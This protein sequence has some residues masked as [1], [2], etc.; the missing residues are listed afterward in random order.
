MLDL[1]L[2]KPEVAAW[3]AR[4]GATDE[5]IAKALGTTYSTWCRWLNG[6]SAIPAAALFHLAEMMGKEPHE[7]REL[8]ED[9]GAAPWIK[10][11][12]PTQPEARAS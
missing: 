10:R 4:H 12:P 3:K 9:A 1:V 6:H 7:I 2:N 11:A 5:T 8:L